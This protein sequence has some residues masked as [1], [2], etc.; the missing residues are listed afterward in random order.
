MYYF[1]GRKKKKKHIKETKTV[2]VKSQ[3]RKKWQKDENS[4]RE[5]DMEGR[6][7]IYEQ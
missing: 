4:N 3:D 5:N 2:N 1:S 7:E 6:D